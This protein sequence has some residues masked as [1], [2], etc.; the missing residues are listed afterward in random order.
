MQRMPTE[1]FETVLQRL[2]VKLDDVAKAKAARLS[3]FLQHI[4]MDQRRNAPHLRNPKLVDRYD[5]LSALMAVFQAEQKEL[6]GDEEQW[7]LAAWQDLMPYL[8]NVGLPDGMK[9]EDRPKPSCAENETIMVVDSQE[10]VADDGSKKQVV[11]LQNGTQR[12][13]S[14]EEQQELLENELMEEIAAETLRMEEQ[15][16]WEEFHAAELRTWEQWAASQD[17]FLQGKRRRAR[18]QI[19]VQ[20]EGGS[21]IKKGNWLFG[22]Q[23][24]QRLLYS[25]SV[26]QNEDDQAGEYDPTAASSGKPAVASAAGGQGEGQVVERSVE[27]P[28]EESGSKAKSLID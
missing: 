9:K 11:V 21:I 19:M 3:G 14:E 5:R 4:M 22:L 7:C 15:N 16:H 10:P 1:D 23:E 8:E 17:D 2:L 12:E 25:V 20:G 28:P 26:I 18:V 27:E 24:G 6:R 13:L